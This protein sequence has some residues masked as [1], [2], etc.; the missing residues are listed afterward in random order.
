MNES[1]AAPAAG[2][3]TLR[4]L[5]VADHARFFKSWLRRIAPDTHQDQANGAE[6]AYR[7]SGFATKPSATP[8]TWPQPAGLHLSKQI[9]CRDKPGHLFCRADLWQAVCGQGRYRGAWS[10]SATAACSTA[11]S[12]APG[13]TPALHA[14][15][16]AMRRGDRARGA[17]MAGQWTDNQHDRWQHAG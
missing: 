9:F 3:D 16:A 5:A 2:F 7:P 4:L 11:R 13:P 12:S 17:R 1:M 15:T 8:V 6:C 10:L 14:S